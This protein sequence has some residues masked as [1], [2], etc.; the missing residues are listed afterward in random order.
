[1]AERA[2]RATLGA[3]MRNLRCSTCGASF[4]MAA[5]VLQGRA[6]VHCPAC[7]RVIVVPGALSRGSDDPDTDAYIEPVPPAEIP[8][9]GGASQPSLFLPKDKR[10]SIVI[11]SGDRKGDV[12]RLEEP[13]V[14]IGRTGS[15]V[16]IEVPDTDV[17]GRH[18]ALECHGAR[19]VLRDLESRNGTFVGSERVESRPVD[20]KTEFRLGGTRFMV[21]VAARD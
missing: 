20:D 18:A 19:V 5:E 11:L 6:T 10:V 9:I 12:V 4:Q 13:R 2:L 3:D 16:D 7:A 14:V 1:M 21:L 17:S 15:G 8:T